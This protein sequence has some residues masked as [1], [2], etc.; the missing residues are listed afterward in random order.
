LGNAPNLF[1][2]RFLL[3]EPTDRDIP[4]IV[5]IAGDWEVA[6]RLARMPHPYGEDNA[7]FF[8]TTIVPAELTWAI[9]DRAAGTMI[10]VIGLAPSGHR[11]SAIQIGYYIARDQWG[12]GVAT[13]AASVVTAY[14]I[15]LV[16]RDR[17]IAQYFADNPASGRVLEKLGFVQLSLSEEPCLAS[18][19]TKRAVNLGLI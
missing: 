11:E 14:G 18:G 17:L 4:E 13:E 19:S 10:G 16:G 2:P 1:T 5:A 9:V 15:G 12:R 8:L 3:R 6:S 7:R